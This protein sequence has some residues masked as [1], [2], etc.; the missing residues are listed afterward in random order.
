MN[1]VVLEIVGFDQRRLGTAIFFFL[2]QHHYSEKKEN[3][4]I[5]SEVSA[6]G[7]T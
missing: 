7:G 3:C 4:F 1:I 6:L 2:T 5:Q